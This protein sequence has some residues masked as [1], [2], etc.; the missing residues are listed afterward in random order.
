[1]RDVVVRCE[2]GFTAQIMSYQ[3]EIEKLSCELESTRDMNKVIET[4]QKQQ[5][6][7]LTRRDVQIEHL[8]D[9]LASLRKA[10]SQPMNVFTQQLD[11]SVSP[12]PVSSSSAQSKNSQ[13]MKSSSSSSLSQPKPSQSSSSS[14]SLA[15]QPKPSTNLSSSSSLLKSLASSKIPEHQ[16]KKA[17]TYAST[18]ISEVISLI[19]HDEEDYDMMES[20]MEGPSLSD[21]FEEI[22]TT[23]FDQKKQGNEDYLD[24]LPREELKS[25][26]H[27]PLAS[28]AQIYRPV[29]NSSSEKANAFIPIEEAA[30]FIHFSMFS[31]GSALPL[32]YS[33]ELPELISYQPSLQPKEKQPTEIKKVQ[34]NFTP[35][36]EAVSFIHPSLLLI[37]SSIPLLYTEEL[38]ELISYQPPQQ[39]MEIQLIETRKVENSWTTMNL[40]PFMEAFSEEEIEDLGIPQIIKQLPVVVD[41]PPNDNTTLGKDNNK[42]NDENEVESSL[43][44]SVMQT[45]DDDVS[46]QWTSSLV[47]SDFFER[48]DESSTDTSFYEENEKEKEECSIDNSTEHV[49]RSIQQPCYLAINQWT[50]I[51]ILGIVFFHQ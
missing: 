29:N 24:N 45:N 51:A 50:I 48:M 6:E 39:V 2:E 40:E 22:L 41:L 26:L 33:E 8:K 20:I 17:I 13:P 23:L 37:E 35:I 44:E 28:L 49:T 18:F 25:M 47:R 38:P 12:I 42:T 15:L 46:S 9:E 31:I 3:Q 34:N 7:Q 1:M 10:Q 36:E 4:V 14:S 30:S 32:I 21:A 11:P 19:L 5:G 16:N 27:E 43:F